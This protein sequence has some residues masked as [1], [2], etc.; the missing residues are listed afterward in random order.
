MRR[1]HLDPSGA[2]LR[3]AMRTISAEAPAEASRFEGRHFAFNRCQPQNTW[4]AGSSISRNRL[5]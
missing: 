5:P 4:S 2:E 3:A 1:A